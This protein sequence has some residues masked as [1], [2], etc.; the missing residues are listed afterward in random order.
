MAEGNEEQEDRTEE[1]TPERRDDF[2][3]RG[4]VAVSREITSVLV[5]ASAVAFLTAYSSLFI[6]SMMNIFTSHF[7]RASWFRV[8]E[9]NIINF[10]IDTSQSAIL[11]ILPLFVVTSAMAIAATFFQTRFNFSWKRLKPD[12]SRINPLKGIPRMVNLQ[13]AME[14]S[15]GIGKMAA[16]GIVSY[17]VLYS[18]WLFV[19]GILTYPI[20]KTWSYWGEIT[21]NLFWGASIILLCIAGVD[22]FYNFMTLEK[23]LKMTKQEV[24]EEF[25]RREVDPHMKGR[26]RRLQR[27]MSNRRMVERTKE[28]TVIITNPTHYSVALKYEMGM[29]APMVIAKGKDFL[30]LQMREAAQAEDIPLVENK[31]LARTLYKVVEIGDQ[32]PESLY[33][34]VSEIIRYVFKLKGVKVNRAEAMA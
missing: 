1:A 4:Q 14:L 7:Q 28:A 16:V 17:L 21:Q 26:M 12:F 22:Y 24:K 3:E 30:A 13:A 5:L 29:A 8:S 9:G 27:E 19:P 20:A 18:E 2:R 33:K 31:P 25:K 10:A 15:K 32:I 11:A 34:A 6:T 23:K